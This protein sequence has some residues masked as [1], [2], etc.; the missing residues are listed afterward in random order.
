MGGA[1][2]LEDQCRNNR[3]YCGGGV[4]VVLMQ[5]WGKAWGLPG[6]WGGKGE[7][8]EGQGVAEEVAVRGLGSP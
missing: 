7:D 4:C 1:R 3:E 5:G 6:Q 8:L 2:G